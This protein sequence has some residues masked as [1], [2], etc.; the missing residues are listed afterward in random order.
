MGGYGSGRWGWHSKRTTVEECRHLDVRY[1]RRHGLLEVD[2]VWQGPLTWRNDQGG[3]DSITVA[4]SALQVALRYTVGPT[5]GPEASRDPELVAYTV[6]VVWTPMFG[7]RTRPWFLCPGRNCG[8]R[9][10]K[11]YLP[12]YGAG[13]KYFLCRHCYGLSYHSRQTWDKRSAFYAKH[14]ELALALM[15]DHVASHAERMAAIKGGLKGLGR[16]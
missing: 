10:A 16:L 13:G 2:R 9:V 1:F 11:L 15:R 8:R 4:A 7:S 12:V 5:C 6:P 3:E 14:P